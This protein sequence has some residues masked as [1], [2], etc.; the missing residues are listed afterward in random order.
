MGFLGLLLAPLIL[1]G[2]T[3]SIEPPYDPND[4]E[5][6]VNHSNGWSRFAWKRKGTWTPGALTSPY[7]RAAGVAAAT[8][9]EVKQMTVTLDG[10]T[11]LLRATPEGGDPRGYFMKESRTY[12]YYD[13]ADLPPGVSTARL[14]IVFSS[15]YYPFYIADTLKNGVWVPDKGGETE[16]VYFYF[17]RLPGRLDQRVVTQ[18]KRTDRNPVEFYLRPDTSTKYRGFAVVDGQ[19]L[20]IVR[21]GRD[22]WIAVPYGR[23]LKAAMAEY[24]KDRAAAESRLANLKKTEAETLTAEYE[25]RMRDHLEKYS[26]EFRTKD[27]AKW[28]IRVAGMEREL[29]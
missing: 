3:P 5:G 25:Q 18:E 7:G 26:G 20:M 14:P 29:A 9:A 12:S 1:A 4:P 13:Q 27:P 17:N 28:K 22:P 11:A 24:E 16:S 15:G 2:Q 21:G 8:A 19:D 10:L 23:A 6:M